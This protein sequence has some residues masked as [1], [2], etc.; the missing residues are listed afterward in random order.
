MRR[1]LVHV[2]FI[3][4]ALAGLH[5]PA[6]AAGVVADL[7]HHLIAITTAFSGTEV[8]LFGALDEPGTDVAVVIRGPEDDTVVRKKTRVGPVWLN[9]DQMTFERAPSYYAVA[10]NKPL[11]EI[12]DATELRRHQI[13]VENISFSLNEEKAE[14]AE[15][16]A[17]TDA[18]VR[19]KQAAALYSSEVS[20]IRF[21]GPKLFRTHHCLSRNC[22]TRKVRGS[23]I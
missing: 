10:A 6:L 5:R 17:Y 19:N 11:V 1:L 12:A 21:I 20:Q 7:S 2:L 22:T 4:A 13:G 9:T 14:Q 8:L 18:L 3:F 16:Q 23:G 15:I